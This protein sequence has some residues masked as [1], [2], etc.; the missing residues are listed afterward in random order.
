MKK[1]YWFLLLFVFVM[2]MIVSNIP[3]HGINY[4]FEMEKEKFENSIETEE[5]HNLDLLPK[6]NKTTKIAKSVESKIYSLFDKLKS[7]I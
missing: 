3:S 5:Y 1:I 4:Y 7:M 6:S 2:G